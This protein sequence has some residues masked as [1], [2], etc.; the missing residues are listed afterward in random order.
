[1]ENSSSWSDPPKKVRDSLLNY[2]TEIE[3]AKQRF[4]SHT[5]TALAPREFKMRKIKFLLLVII[6]LPWDVFAG[7]IDQNYTEIKS[8]IVLKYKDLPPGK[9]FMPHNQILNTDRKAIALTF[10]A[11]GGKGG[12]GYNKQLIDYLMTENVPATM[13]ISGKWIDENKKTFLELA[14]NELFEIANHGLNH[15]ALST[16]GKSI[17]SIQGTKNIDE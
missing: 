14:N 16:N 5:A 12:S 13:F 6:F 9:F 7:S 1:M 4:S 8:N 11:C 10:D 2:L 3:M 17:Y 15:E